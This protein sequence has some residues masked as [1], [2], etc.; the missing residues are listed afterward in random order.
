MFLFLDFENKQ[1][2]VP[3]I[4][5]ESERNSTTALAMLYGSE[6][7]KGNFYPIMSFYLIKYLLSNKMTFT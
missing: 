5:D 7:V 4:T 3:L 2:V 1:D 6:L